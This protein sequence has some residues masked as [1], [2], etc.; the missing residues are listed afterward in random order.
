MFNIEIAAQVSAW[1]INKEGGKIP[2]LKLIKLLYLTERTYIKKYNQPLFG[3]DLYA[4]EHGPILSTT[5]DFIR[6]EIHPD[7]SED[8]DKWVSPKEDHQIS[9]VRKFRSNELDLLSKA[10]IAI[11]KDLWAEH[12]NKD[13]WD[14]VD[15][16]H[17]HCKEWK[18]PG[19]RSSRR[20][21]YKTLLSW[22]FGY[23][24]DEVNQ[25]LDNLEDQKKLIHALYQP[26]LKTI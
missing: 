3:D 13:Q 20:I 9:L 16:T 14:M 23:D 2:H 5:L 24:D 15:Y 4:M 1:F 8:W 7:D 21:S 25:R 19:E 22:G 6:G 26:N 11:L 17:E 18:D 10:I 12:K